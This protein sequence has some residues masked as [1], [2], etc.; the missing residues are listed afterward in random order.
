MRPGR[1]R[2]LRAKD[3]ESDQKGQLQL[4]SSERYIQCLN[5][6]CVVC[7]GLL[8]DSDP[9]AAGGGQ[10]K[11][12]FVTGVIAREKI[13][14]FERILWRACRGNV[15]LRQAAIEHP[16]DDPAT[17]SHVTLHDVCDVTMSYLQGDQVYKVVFILFFQGDQLRTRVRK[18]CEG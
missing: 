13:P 4:F 18:I 9:E 2:R 11:F 16:L 6:L 15:F 1:D 7:A 5:S 3:A 10:A 17:V 12:T 14:A 8:V